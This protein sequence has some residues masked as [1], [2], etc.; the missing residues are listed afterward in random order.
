M[1]ETIDNQ[2]STQGEGYLS[3]L[4][5]LWRTEGSGDSSTAAWHA[6]VEVPMS[7]EKHSFPDLQSLFTFLEAQT[8]QADS[9]GSGGDQDE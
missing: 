4:M 1:S 5:R 9:Q 8:G 2:G 6:S 7:R 3:Y